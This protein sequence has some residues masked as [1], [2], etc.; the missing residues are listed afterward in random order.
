M[1]VRLGL[2]ASFAFFFIMLDYYL[3]EFYSCKMLEPGKGK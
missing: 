1:P 2:P 3:I